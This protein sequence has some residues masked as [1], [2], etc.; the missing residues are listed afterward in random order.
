MSACVDV[1]FGDTPNPNSMVTVK[2]ECD[3]IYVNVEINPQVIVVPSS[4]GSAVIQNISVSTSGAS[5]PIPP[6][7][8]EVL[9]ASASYPPI[10]V[11]QTNGVISTVASTIPATPI[12]GATSLP[13]SALTLGTVSANI[14]LS[15]LILATAT[16]FAV[17]FDLV[18]AAPLLFT[19][20]NG[21]ISQ[22]NTYSGLLQTFL[23][24]LLSMVIAVLITTLNNVITNV[25]AA[26]ITALNTLISVTNSIIIQ[27]QNLLGTVLYSVVSDLISALTI[28]SNSGVPG[29]SLIITSLGVS[30]NGITA[31]NNNFTTIKTTLNGINLAPLSALLTTYSNTLT[32]LSTLVT[33]LLGT[34]PTISIPPLPASIPVNF[35]VTIPIGTAFNFGS[36]SAP[37]NLG[38]I[39][40]GAGSVTL[41][42]LN[43]PVLPL[44]SLSGTPVMLPNI[45]ANLITLPAV[46]LNSLTFNPPTINMP[47]ISVI[48]PSTT[49]AVTLPDQ[50]ISIP[51]LDIDIKIRP[52]NCCEDDEVVCDCDSGPRVGPIY[53]IEPYERRGNRNRKNRN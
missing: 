43:T 53:Q 1:T 36:I 23:N 45:P 30:L 42:A 41:P 27:I 51:V 9:L 32:N 39:P 21:L 29:L 52:D 19:A 31:I 26:L 34:I 38:T 44:T 12:I 11:P 18:T 49:V 15:N 20:L 35:S 47:P 4:T 2:T 17:S 25:L 5:V 28:I 37:I 7:V 13:L 46:N 50:T 8:P 10:S 14:N 22:I 6:I 48:V 33:T 16:S 3:D 24:N 40:A